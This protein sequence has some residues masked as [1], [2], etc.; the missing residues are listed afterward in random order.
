[1]SSGKVE[2]NR[3]IVQGSAIG[4]YLYLIF[5]T[6]FKTLGHKNFIVKYA[7][8]TILGIPSNSDIDARQEFEHTLSLAK[9]NKLQIN[10]LKTKEMIFS[11][12]KPIF[13]Y[14]Q[15][16]DDIELVSK[17]KYLGI[18]IDNKL[19]FSNHITNI[20]T[21]CSQRL[22]LM[23]N[24]KLQGLNIDCLECIFDSLIVSKIL[25]CLPAW[26]GFLKETDISRINSLFKRAKRN[27]YTRSIYDF[28]GLLNHS[29]KTLFD[30][31]NNNNK[32]H[33]LHH[34]LS[35][36]RN[37]LSSLRTRGHDLILPQYRTSLFRN[38]FIIRSLYCFM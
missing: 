37:L 7:D 24:L 18:L 30:K 3:G 19:N 11:K 23:R 10:Q 38:S 28:R 9:E 4:P 17:F 36:K 12:P 6:D 31:I 20:L 8:D 5:Q 27:G 2:I 21:I 32:T 35:G 13:N 33:C 1:M 26:G 34:L 14:F 25:Y 16:F 22:Y 29:D 15:T